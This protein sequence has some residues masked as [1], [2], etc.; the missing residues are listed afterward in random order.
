MSEGK[1]LQ[2]VSIL[3][4]DDD[5]DF[6]L[7]NK[8]QLEALGSRVMECESAQAARELLERETPDVVVVDL[9]MEEED[10]GF[11][12][13][14]YIKQRWP[15]LPIVLATGVASETGFEFATG[16]VEERA[17][18]KAD[19]VLPKPIRFEQLLGEIKK[20]LALHG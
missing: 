17:W 15:T 2:G 1:N 18:I 19:T 10:S 12:L 14:Y 7:Q 3:I 20:L 16:T 8:L 4:V 11:A 5:Y 9:M 6:R 13:C